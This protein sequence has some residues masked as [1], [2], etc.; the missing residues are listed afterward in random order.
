MWESALNYDKQTTSVLST[1]HGDD[2]MK[3][4]VIGHSIQVYRRRDYHQVTSPP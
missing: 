3:C 4:K 1:N 2:I